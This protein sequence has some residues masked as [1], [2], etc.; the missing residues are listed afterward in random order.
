VNPG[1]KRRRARIGALTAM[2]GALFALVAAR[3]AMLVLIDGPRLVSMARS[4]HR[5]AISLAAV[6]GP[7]LDRNGKPLALSAET[8]S[9]Y[10]R[11]R[12]LLESTTEADRVKLAAVLEMEPATLERRLARKAPFVWLA[13]HQSAQRVRAFDEIGLEGVGSVPEYFRF[14]PESGLAAAVVGKAGADGQGL[15]GVELEYDRVVRGAPSVMHFD[16]DARGHAIF[17]SPLEQAGAQAGDRLELT[18]DAAIQT[19][20]EGYLASEVRLSGARGGTAIVLDPFTGEVLAMANANVDDS[21]DR[22]RL[23]N[24]GVQDAFEPGSTL[25]G[26]VGAI[27]LDDQVIDTRRQ[28]FCERGVWHVAGKTIHDDSPRGWLDLGSIIE[29]SSNIGAAKLA[30]ALGASRLAAGLAVFGIGRKTGIDLPGETVGVLRPVASWRPIELADHGFGQGLAVTPIQLATAYAAIANGGVVMRP[31]VLK[32][33]YDADGR[34]ILRHTPQ[35]LRRAVSPATAHS[36]NLLLRGVVNQPDGTGHLAQVADFTVAGKTGTAQMVNP[37]T[38]GYYQ[39]RLVA[40]FVGFVPAR[41]PRLV[42]LVVLYDVA[43]GHFGG[44]FAAPVFSAIASSALQHLEVPPERPTYETASMFPFGNSRS[45]DAGPDNDAAANPM[46]Q[47]DAPIVGSD[48]EFT[49]DFIGLSLRGA[50]ALARAQGLSPEVEGGGY[51]IAQDPAPGAVRASAI[52]L[53]LASGPAPSAE[54]FAHGDHSDARTQ[55]ARTSTSGQQRK[56]GIN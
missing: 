6:R 26:I 37:A 40:S 34:E 42:V 50:L 55:V 36:M 5:G 15:S 9:V 31:Y 56:R 1:F 3:L 54:H 12:R 49:P 38:G 52:S 29:V 48:R 35:V 24:S 2:I 41:D 23:H 28:I 25:K 14:Y 53:K 30:S 19:Q 43:H 21:A 18:I 13:R 4:E 39:S 17:D 46:A 10:A 22:A 51:V 11:P 27:A 45:A 33:A 16:H 47:A 44:L 8:L 32:A 7:I 20:A